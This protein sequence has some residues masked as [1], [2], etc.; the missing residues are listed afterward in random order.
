MPTVAAKPTTDET[1][2]AANPARTER[3]QQQESQQPGL[4]ATA[5]TPA[6]SKLL[7]RARKGFKNKTPHNVGT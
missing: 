4:P 6:I 7:S 1:S 2:S 5:G 3:Q